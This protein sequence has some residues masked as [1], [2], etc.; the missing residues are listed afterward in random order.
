M[1]RG[2]SGRGGTRD[3]DANRTRANERGGAAAGRTRAQIL[4]A[5]SPPSSRTGRAFTARSSFALRL[6][7]FR[8]CEGRIVSEWRTG[9]DGTTAS[10]P[11]ESIVSRSRG[12]RAPRR[13]GAHLGRLRRL[14][15][16][17]LDRRVSRRRRL[18]LLRPRLG[19]DVPP[20]GFVPWLLRVLRDHRARRSDADDAKRPRS[21]RPAMVSGSRKRKSNAKGRGRVINRRPN[22]GCGASSK[23]AASGP[24]VMV[25]SQPQPQV[26]DVWWT[27]RAV[28][29]EARSSDP[30]SPRTSR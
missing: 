18:L 1:G 13:D 5:R 19:L 17:G 15:G 3:A 2:V 23:P 20:A 6:R 25:V 22:M 27:R 10:A 12:G 24:K 7:S 11:R 8:S 9:R 14:R 29:R 21:T 26:R 28:A 16:G 30:A 4:H